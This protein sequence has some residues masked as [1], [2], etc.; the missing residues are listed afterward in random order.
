MRPEYHQQGRRACWNMDELEI[1]RRSFYWGWWVELLA[2]GGGQ[3][4]VFVVDISSPGDRPPGFTLKEAPLSHHQ[5]CGLGG[6]EPSSILGWAV[7]GL[8]HP[9]P[10]CHHGLFQN[11]HIVQLKATRCKEALGHLGEPFALPAVGISQ[12]TLFL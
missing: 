6:I 3:D 2:G 12:E 9:R 8:S 1:H 7:I 4:K 5:P 11:R 10:L